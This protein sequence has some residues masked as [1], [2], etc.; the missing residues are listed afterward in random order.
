MKLH[1]IIIFLL[2]TTPH[3]AQKS[4][5]D[6]LEQSNNKS[7]PY[8]SVQE[9]AMP[10][11]NAIVLD[12][13]ERDEFM[14]SHLKGAKHVGYNTFKIDSI[15]NH[16]PNKKQP[17]VVYCSVGIRSE[18]IAAQLKKA[19]YSNV[20]NLYGGIFE[21][22]NNN[23]KVFDSEEK[24]T[25][26]VHVFSKYWGKWLTNGNKILNGSLEQTSN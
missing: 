8:I 3:L 16:I 19:G 17:I 21:W 9:L 15:T 14:I 20:Y 5:D 13:R 4:I 23:F 10:K 7:V 24:E 11:T 18:I 26:N 25:E 2:S 12:A 22:K 6:L 1:L